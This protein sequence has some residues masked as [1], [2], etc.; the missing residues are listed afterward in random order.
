MVKKFWIASLIFSMNM[1]ALSPKER[2]LLARPELGRFEI[3]IGEAWGLAG[4][5][6][7]NF[8]TLHGHNSVKLKGLIEDVSTKM[9]LH[10]LGLYVYGK[11][12]KKEAFGV[13]L[14]SEFGTKFKQEH[15][16]IQSLIRKN[17]NSGLI[18][19]YYARVWYQLGL[20]KR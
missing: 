12:K 7:Q 13:G 11:A 16:L 20:K 9:A 14:L 17:G 3:G 1:F 2:A 8:K 18:I 4:R 6:E 15:D 5:A 19:V 10:N